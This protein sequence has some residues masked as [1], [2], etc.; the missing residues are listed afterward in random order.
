MST[1]LTPEVAALID[2]ANADDWL[3]VIL[4]LEPQSRS[5]GAS[6]AKSRTE[7][8]AAQKEAFLRSLSPVE[9]T[10]QRLG[11]EITGQ[12]WIN[13]SVRVRVPAKS[14]RE[15]SELRGIATLDVPHPLTAEAR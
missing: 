8:I 7:K 13:R 9:E 5:E 1:E 15:L 6:E 12:A 2:S 10:I 4:E 3:E 14:V 11:G